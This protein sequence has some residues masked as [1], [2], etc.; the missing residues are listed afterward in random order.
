[1]PEAPERP[2]EGQGRRFRLT[3]AERLRRRSEFQQVYDRGI[4]LHGRFQTM[5][6]LPTDRPVSRLGVAATRKL[7][8]AVVRNRIKRQVRELFRLNKPGAGLD[9]VVVPR[10]GWAS[11]PYA[12]LESDYRALLRRVLGRLR[13]AGQRRA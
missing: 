12:S 6:A 3:P 2:P 10:Q 13:G 1:M 5:F 11:A 9:I 7:G 4:K 8:G